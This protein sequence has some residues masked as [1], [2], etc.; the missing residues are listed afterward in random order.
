MDIFIWV[1]V[2]TTITLFCTFVGYFKGIGKGY[3]KGA[4]DV[5]EEWKFSL[6]EEEVNEK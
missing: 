5:L 3:K 2:S 6:G 1:M 4:A